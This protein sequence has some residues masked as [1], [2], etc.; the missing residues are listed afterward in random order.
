MAGRLADLPWPASPSSSGLL[1]GFA[2][3]NSQLH[4]RKP[5]ASQLAYLKDLAMKTGQS[6]AYPQTSAQASAE[7]RRLKG[8]KR[9]PSADRRREARQVRHDLAERRGD[10]A[11]VR[12]EELG[13]Y[14]SR[15]TWR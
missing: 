13:G 6:F 11:S 7:I 5:T 8:T 14:G 3:T 12:P 4:L 1:V 2:M 15:A 10:S 9:T